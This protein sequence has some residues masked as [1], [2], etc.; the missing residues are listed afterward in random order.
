MRVVVSGTKSIMK[1][2][3]KNAET[4]RIYELYEILIAI[5]I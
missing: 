1:A 3:E 2:G 4:P 5:L